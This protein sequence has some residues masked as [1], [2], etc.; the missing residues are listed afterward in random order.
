MMVSD[1]VNEEEGLADLFK[2]VVKA[3]VSF[4]KKVANNTER[5]LGIAINIDP[6]MATMNPA[7]VFFSTPE[8]VKFITTGEVIRV[9]QKY[10]H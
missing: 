9:L 8:L 7:R 2:N 3:A 10:R 5:T 1:A 4:W 6:S